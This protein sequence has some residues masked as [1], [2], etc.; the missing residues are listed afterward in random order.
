M[1]LKSFN[2]EP[3]LKEQLVS[4]MVADKKAEKL[5]KGQ[6]YD[7]EDGKGCNIGCAEFELCR[8][9]GDKFTNSKD[10]YLAKKLQIPEFLFHLGDTIFEELPHKESQKWAG[11][12][13]WKSIPVGKD[14]ILL[15]NQI[16]IEILINPD[17][18]CYQYAT[19][20]IKA[21]INLIV[22]LHKAKIDGKEWDESAAR[23]ARS[24]AEAAWSAAW[25]V[26]WSARSAE[27]SARS[28]AARSVAWSAR[29]AAESAAWSAAEA[30][31][32]SAA[33]SA[34]SAA[35]RSARSEFFLK[36]SEKIIELMKAYK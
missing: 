34:R 30:T 35:A 32:R 29:S 26:A 19:D 22:A 9:T 25:S 12:D 15:E 2:N 27:E 8:I 18:G 31:A 17:F 23:S 3:K 4:A 11:I 36:L 5:V 24:A 21:I 1:S 20:E 14:L 28:A 33:E 16:K 7:Y 10:K 6:Y 13:F